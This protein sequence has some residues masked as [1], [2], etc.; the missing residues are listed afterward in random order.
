MHLN[1]YVLTWE[2]YT[3]Y[4]KTSLTEPDPTGSMRPL[5]DSLRDQYN[6]GTF[7]FTTLADPTLLCMCV[8]VGVGGRHEKPAH[9]Y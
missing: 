7:L 1:L 9:S 6:S 4:C 3:K 2:G 8:C 5:Q